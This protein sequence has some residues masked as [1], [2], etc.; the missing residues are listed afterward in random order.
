MYDLIHYVERE[1]KVPFLLNSNSFQTYVQLTWVLL[2]CRRR[3]ENFSLSALRRRRVRSTT[4]SKSHSNAPQKQT[5]NA[6][7]T[8]TIKSKTWDQANEG[9]GTL[10]VL[11]KTH[12]K[13]VSCLQ[14]VTNFPKNLS[15]KLQLF[16][17][18]ITL[19]F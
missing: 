10:E 16:L 6:C 2:L 19:K 11:G 18:Y 9:R 15:S 8:S 14:K 5:S 12:S 7:K 3:S 1:G 13:K 4:S 17:S